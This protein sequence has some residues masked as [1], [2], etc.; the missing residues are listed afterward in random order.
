MDLVIEDDLLVETVYLLMSEDSIRKRKQIVLPWVSFCADADPGGRR[1]RPPEI[2]HVYLRAFG[3]FAR[4]YA[5]YVRDEKLLTIAEAVRKMTSLPASDLG[6]AWRGRLRPYVADI[7][8][9]DPATIQ[10]H[11]TLENPRQTA[12]GVSEVFINGT[13][14]VHHGEDTGAKPG[15]VVRRERN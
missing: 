12:T 4:L 10:D 7:A 5:R 6:L 3:N 1:R 8:V 9:F 15:R 14:V 2:Q 13:E 11:A